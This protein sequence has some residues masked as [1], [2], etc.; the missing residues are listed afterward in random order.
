MAN[1]LEEE[2]RLNYVGGNSSVLLFLLNSG[3]LQNND[4]VLEQARKLNE[5]VPGKITLLPAF[6]IKFDEIRFLCVN[7]GTYP[8]TYLYD[9]PV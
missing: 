1:E 4:Q 6:F 7:L 2:K 3:N 5:T 9:Y 8:C